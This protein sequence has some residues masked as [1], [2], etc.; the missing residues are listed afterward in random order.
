MARP[1]SQWMPHAPKAWRLA[2]VL[3]A[4]TAG[5]TACQGAS[6]PTL[7]DQGA[8]PVPV[9]LQSSPSG[10]RVSVDGVPVG[11]APVTLPLRAGP[12]RVRMRMSGYFA[13]DTRVQV[14]AGMP[15]VALKLIAS[16]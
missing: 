14:N 7:P 5:S 3:L 12:H 11:T 1:V 16:H 9:T 13:Q 6:A 8:N 15:P 2:L 10:A 4:V